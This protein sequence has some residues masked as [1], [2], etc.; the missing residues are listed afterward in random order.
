MFPLLGVL[1][2]DWSIHGL[3]LVYWLESGIIGLLNV[4]KILSA[5][6]PET[7]A[8]RSEASQLT[9]GGNTVTLP[10]AP[11]I[12]PETLTWRRENWD[13][14]VFF[15]THYGLFWLFHGV[16]IGIFPLIATGMAFVP[17]TALSTIAVGVGAVGVSHYISYQQNYV[18]G[19]EW[20][21][22][23]PGRRVN[24]PYDRVVVLHLTIVLGAFVVTRIDAPLGALVVMIGI[25]IALDIRGHLREHSHDSST[26]AKPS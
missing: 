17:Y 26:P 12:V 13:V 3:L 7:S 10:D 2:Y 1:A 6:G 4:P 8:S 11:K 24:A 9:A 15:T 21:T 23:P 16:F 20:R 25:K 22:A 14:A 5:H 19:G 18:H